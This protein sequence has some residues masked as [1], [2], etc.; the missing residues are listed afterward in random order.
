MAQSDRLASHDIFGTPENEI[1]LSTKPYA[2]LDPNQQEI[3]LLKIFPGKGNSLVRCTLLPQTRLVDVRGRYTALS[4]CAGDSKRTGTILVNG[5]RCNVFA[6][7]MH[8]MM[9]ARYFWRQTRRHRSFLLWVDQICIN[10]K[11]IRERSHQV[12]FMRDIYEQA[13]QVLVCLSTSEGPSTGMEWLALLAGKVPARRFDADEGPLPWAKRWEPKARYYHRNRLSQYIQRHMYDRGFSDGW[14]AFCDVIESPWWERAWVF[15]EFVVAPKVHILYRRRFI[16]WEKLWPI[17]R[18]LLH[19]QRSLLLGSHD[20]AKYLP[21]SCIDSEAFLSEH[22]SHVFARLGSGRVRSTLELVNFM[23][24]ARLGRDHRLDLKDLLMN[25]RYCHTSDP[26]DKVYA[27]IG[28]SDPGYDIR[29]DYSHSIIEVLIETTQKIML[30][31]NS[32]DVL[33]HAAASNTSECSALPSWVVD[34]TREERRQRWQRHDQAFQEFPRCENLSEN[35]S[36][37]SSSPSFRTIS[38]DGHARLCLDVKG[39]FIDSIKKGES[40]LLFQTTNHYVVECSDEAQPQDEIWLL[41]GARF[42]VVLRP[43]EEG[44]RLISTASWLNRWPLEIIV[45]IAQSGQGGLQRVS[46]I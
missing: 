8:A 34:W 7:L 17:L 26:R 28:L 15:Q 10:Q 46:I 45:K 2:D 23:G 20:M 42:L 44:H 25:S 21:E 38:R 6:N 29:P 18:S 9:E 1:F 43:E 3:R 39:T 31:E 35:Y 5:T 19:F 40:L 11:D 14:T 16:C 24:Q 32:L 13:K 37:M 36:Q 41:D 30:F 33:A 22:V 27:F 12:G 4:Y